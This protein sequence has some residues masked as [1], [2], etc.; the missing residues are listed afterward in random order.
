MGQG[1]SI[2]A[3]MATCAKCFRAWPVAKIVPCPWPRAVM[4]VDADGGKRAVCASHAAHPSAGDLKSS[5]S[6]SA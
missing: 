3:G 1:L 4:L 5:R 6:G 2:T